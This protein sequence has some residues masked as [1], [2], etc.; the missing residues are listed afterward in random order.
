MNWQTDK[1]LDKK[2]IARQK[3]NCQKERK[4]AEEINEQTDK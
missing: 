3:E 2:I 4:I 1:L